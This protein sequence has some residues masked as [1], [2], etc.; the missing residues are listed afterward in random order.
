MTWTTLAASDTAAASSYTT[1]MDLSV[2][3]L[4]GPTDRHGFRPRL[5][6]LGV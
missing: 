3:K 5:G 6:G 4:F 1:V 2:V